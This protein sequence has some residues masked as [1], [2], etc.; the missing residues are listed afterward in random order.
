MSTRLERLIYIAARIGEGNYPSIDTFAG[1]FEVSKRTIKHDLEFLQSRVD[2]P[3][4]YSRS[5]SGYYYTDLNS[6]L[7][8]LP[9]TE[10]QLLAFFLSVEL[11][12]AVKHYGA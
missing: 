10:G 5:R 8:T 9:V 4:A 2:A 6:S 3:I 12:K 11:D 1:R 7:S